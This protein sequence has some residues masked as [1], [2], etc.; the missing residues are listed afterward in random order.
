MLAA[1][2]RADGARG[3]RGEG[4]EVMVRADSRTW[5][6]AVV[7]VLA[8]SAIADE[9]ASIGLTGVQFKNATNQSRSSNPDTIDPYF[10]YTY[11]ITGKAKGNGGLL[12]ILFPSATDLG[13]ILETL[14]PGSSA[15][16]SG[17][18]CNTAGTHPFQATDM[19][20]SGTQVIS[21]I[22]VTFSAT[23]SV[24][25]DENDF[26]FF[27]LTDVTLSPSFLVGSLQMT[28]GSVVL[29]GVCT[30]DFDQSGFVDTDDFDAFV[31]A[32]EAG[33]ASADMDCTG[34][35]DTDDFDTFVRRFEMGC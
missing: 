1:W 22:E 34:F 16:L 3:W 15:M 28:E 14:S 32:F 24:G 26:A 25:I 9:T 12:G 7:A 27:N 18:A 5:A 23:I 13:T 30:A 17:T 8:G 6:A 29:T 35:V 19:Q 2:V 20:V 11:S 31:A 21:G 33:D 10:A 4:A